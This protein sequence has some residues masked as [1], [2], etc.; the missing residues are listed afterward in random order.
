MRVVAFGGG[1]KNKNSNRGLV[2]RGGFYESVLKG[3][4][5]HRV[6]LSLDEKDQNF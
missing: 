1:A 3:R 4:V 2:S 5:L 6:D